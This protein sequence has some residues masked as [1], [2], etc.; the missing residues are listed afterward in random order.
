MGQL[1]II[2]LKDKS[3][4]NITA[5]NKVLK[6]LKIKNS[7]TAEEDNIAW[8]E[9]INNNP[10]SAQKHLKPITLEELKKVFGLWCEAGSM[11]FDVAFSRTTQ[12]EAKKYAAFIQANADLIESI[13]SGDDLIERYEL[14]DDEVKTIEKLTLKK[15]EP[16]KLPKEQQTKQDL[17][18]GLFL[19]KTWSFEPFWLI[20]GN[21]ERPI[22]LKNKIYEEDIYNN[23]YRDK[24]NYAYLMIPLLPLNDKQIDFVSEVY[25]GAA[26]MGLRENYNFIIP[27]IY[28]LDL[29]GYDAVVENYRESYSVEE[30]QDRFTRV[31]KMTT[32]IY[33]YNETNGIVWRDTKKQF[34]PCGTNN[35]TMQHQAKCSI[36]TCLVRAL[37]PEVAAETMTTLLGKPYKEF[38]FKDI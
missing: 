7:F 22:F 11:S 31:F 15:T 24:N 13:A 6:K 10:D 30:L 35:A 32:D 9:D 27:L 16:K 37:P 20:F 23:I 4:K 28:G 1:V 34:N 25:D 2:R 21:V 5:V 29:T 17:Q 36:L 33:P 18:G 14:T 3:D 12:K 19:C 26:D 8:V 38:E